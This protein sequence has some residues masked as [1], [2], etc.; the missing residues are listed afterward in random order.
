MNTLEEHLI[1]ELDTMNPEKGYNLAPGGNNHNLTSET[2]QK[3]SDR[4]KEFYATEKGQ[5]RKRKIGEQKKQELETIRK[6][7]NRENLKKARAAITPEGR[8]KANKALQDY[9]SN[10][11]KKEER[12][13]NGLKGAV[14][15]SKVVDVYDKNKNLIGTFDSGRKAAKAL[16]IN[17]STPSYALNHSHRSGDYYFFFHG[18]FDEKVFQND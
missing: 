4:L 17:H 9:Y 14:V 2:R 6:E 15:R 10:P 5:E 18:E 7:S 13:L 8:A 12:R 1:Q 16:G 3:I 11:E